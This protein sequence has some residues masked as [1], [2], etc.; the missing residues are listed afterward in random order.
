L[1]LQRKVVVIIPALNEEKS[2]GKVIADIPGDI[3]NEVVVVDNGS[4]DQ[5]LAVV[6]D[7]GATALIQPDRGYGNACLKAIN[8]FAE[9]KLEDQPDIVVFMDGDYSDYPIEISGVIEPIIR[10]DYDMVIG[11][12][13]IG[14]REK[15]S[16]TPQQRIGNLIATFLLRVLYKVKYT[17]LGPF[18]A[19]KFDKLIQI[20]MQDKTYGWTVEMQIK[21]AKLGFRSIEVP[22][23]YR[24]RIG[25]SKVS[26]TVSGVVKAGTKI[27]YTIFKSM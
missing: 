17:D 3:V 1:Q 24:K 12:R 8:Y 11:S 23:S 21:A 5:T 15:G 10:Q 25:K 9:K 27:I 13:I 2:I 4:S 14:K 26:G 20:D 19:I 7:S 16:L 6:R 22:V 18:R